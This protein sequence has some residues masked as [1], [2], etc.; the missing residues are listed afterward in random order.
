[1]YGKVRHILGG[2]KLLACLTDM[3]H[4]VKCRE[5]NSCMS[6]VW[7]MPNRY[8][9]CSLC[10]QWYGGRDG[11]LIKV[12]NPNQDK[13]DEVKGKIEDPVFEKDGNTGNVNA[14]ETYTV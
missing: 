2:H 3:A 14:E 1:M 11:E 10:L 4:R 9:Y 6:P 5:C 13:I 8:Y 12:A 7:V